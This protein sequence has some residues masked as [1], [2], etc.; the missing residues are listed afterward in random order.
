MLRL[1]TDAH[2]FPYKGTPSVSNNN[3]IKEIPRPEDEGGVLIGQSKLPSCPQLLHSWS[4][5]CPSLEDSVQG[6][7]SLKS[8]MGLT[9][10]KRT[11]ETE[12]AQLSGEEHRGSSQE[13]STHGPD[14]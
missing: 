13:S 11:D 1:I 9:T 4:S 14:L 6:S 12:T 5:L 8:H 2:I 10:K 7:H 3:D